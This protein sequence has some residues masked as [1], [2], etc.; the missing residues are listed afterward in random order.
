MRSERPSVEVPSCDSHAFLRTTH[1]IPR[2]TRA[3]QESTHGLQVPGTN[4]G[5]RANSDV[6]RKIRSTGNQGQG[7][8]RTGEQEQW[9][10][11]RIQGKAREVKKNRYKWIASQMA[12]EYPD[13]AGSTQEYPRR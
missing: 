4:P 1:K 5:T 7:K 13:E 6:P 11:K 10:C 9:D 12:C 3:G 2:D 8:R